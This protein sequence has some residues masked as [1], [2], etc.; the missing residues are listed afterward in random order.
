MFVLKEYLLSH[1]VLELICI[2]RAARAVTL[3]GG[4]HA[5]A[6]F[7]IASTVVSSHR[8]SSHTRS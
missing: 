6:R 5:G 4:M 7:M 2:A 1:Q 3:S 8:T